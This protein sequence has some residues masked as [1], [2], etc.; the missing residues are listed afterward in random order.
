[1]RFLNKEFFFRIKFEN[2]VVLVDEVL[3]DFLT[4]GRLVR[5]AADHR[6]VHLE[7]TRLLLTME[8]QLKMVSGRN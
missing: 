8:N 2:L 1:M 5:V 3:P 7:K 4:A 6:D